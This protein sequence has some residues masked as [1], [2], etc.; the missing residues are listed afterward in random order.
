MLT[1]ARGRALYHE[2]VNQLCEMILSGE[3]SKGD[4]LPSENVLC[5][6]MGVSRTTIRE[7]LRILQE[8]NIIKT[9]KG[10]GSIVISDDFNYVDESERSN[11]LRFQ[12]TL[13]NA[14]EARLLFEPAI[15]RLACKTATEQDIEDMQNAIN[16]CNK[17]D[18]E[19]TATSKD[20][21]RFHFLVARATH[22]PVL[23]SVVE[24]MISMCDA[25][26]SANVAAPNPNFQLRTGI[27]VS[28]E[29]ILEAIK[30]KQE[31]DAFFYMKENIKEFYC[32][33][34]TEITPK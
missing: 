16:I 17:K 29:M 19:G 24:L 28:H 3:V 25:P 13:E 8:R 30:A 33:T 26:P 1:K 7:A 9:I 10:K 32:N 15:A 2:V 11:L 27:N 4:L 21:R 5:S 34:L 18:K 6:Q 31:E 14:V 12:N 22:N 23:E 20:L